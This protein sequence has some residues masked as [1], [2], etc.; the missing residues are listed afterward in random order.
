MKGGRP[1]SSRGEVRTSECYLWASDLLARMFN[2]PTHRVLLQVGGRK[3]TAV[4]KITAMLAFHRYL[5]GAIQTETRGEG[6]LGYGPPHAL[7]YPS[8]VGGLTP[9]HCLLQFCRHS[10]IQANQRFRRK[11]TVKHKDKEKEKQPAGGDVPVQFRPGHLLADLLDECSQRWGVT[12]N[13]AAKRLAVL[14]ACE[15]DARHHD[16]VCEL[17]EA[18]PG[19]PDFIQ[20]CE[21]LLGELQTIERT[22]ASLEQGVLDENERQEEIRQIVHLHSAYRSETVDETK[23]I[24]VREHRTR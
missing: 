16:H 21:R 23:K 17:A 22:R 3:R 1:P 4:L 11:R 10:H 5:W 18:L 8:G 19:Q 14:A 20:A 24:R 6:R 2:S 15:L 13:E 12:R 7:M 9:R